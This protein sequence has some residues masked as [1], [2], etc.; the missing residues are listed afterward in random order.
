M[1]AAAEE[2]LKGRRNFHSIDGTSE[3]TGLDAGS[4]DIITA[5]QAFH[6]FRSE[7]TS[8]EFMRILRPGGWIALLWNE[9][10]LDTTPFLVEYEKFLLEYAN[11]YAKVR[12][13]NIDA[14]RLR[15]FFG[16][17]PRTATFAN[18]QVFDLEGLLGRVSSSSYMPSA[19]DPRYP[20]MAEAL[21]RLF[22]KHEQN[23]RISVFYNTNVFYTQY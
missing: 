15:E 2:F 6:W 11:D 16:R 20:L 1:R 4:V 14:E 19:S 9:R 10:Q 13:D 22:A 7:E 8:A 5:A 3:A 23:G 12:H 17:D 21:K 18:T